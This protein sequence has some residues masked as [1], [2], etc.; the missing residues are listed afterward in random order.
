MMHDI[1][2][3]L[4]SDTPTAFAPRYT[5][6]SVLTASYLRPSATGSS[7]AA[8]RDVRILEQRA[9][10]TLRDGKD[11]APPPSD[12]AFI[13][14]ETGKRAVSLL[15]GRTASI[16]S[17]ARSALVYYV[18]APTRSK[19]TV[20]ERPVRVALAQIIL[21]LIYP[22]GLPLFNLPCRCP[23]IAGGSW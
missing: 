5:L 13:P 7:I 11:F 15:P 18:A 17:T 22:L 4:R 3:T 8:S 10:S 1:C 21:A 16:R 9:S 23:W 6:G 20:H 2:A 19:L 14:D 12:D